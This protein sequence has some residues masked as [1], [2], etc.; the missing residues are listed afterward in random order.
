MK[1]ENINSKLWLVYTIS[2][3]N[4]AIAAA[5]GATALLGSNYLMTNAAE[6]YG[7]GTDNILLQ[8]CDTMYFNFKP[9]F[10]MVKQ[11][12]KPDGGVWR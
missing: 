1:D 5:S 8:C 10:N 6:K 2:G 11:Y 7:F 4:V 12:F 3:L 9:I